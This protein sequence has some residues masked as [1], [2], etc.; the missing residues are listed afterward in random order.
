MTWAWIIGAVL[1]VA[2]LAFILTK[3]VWAIRTQPQGR[4]Q[5]PSRKRRQRRPDNENR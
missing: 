3:F 2:V 1:A 5:A 4:W